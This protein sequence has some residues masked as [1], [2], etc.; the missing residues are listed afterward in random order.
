MVIREGRGAVKDYSACS[1]LSNK[2]DQIA[3]STSFLDQLWDDLAVLFHKSC[4]D[5]PSVVTPK[6]KLIVIPGNHFIKD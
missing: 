3:H 1:E 4:F 2:A 6:R 5:N